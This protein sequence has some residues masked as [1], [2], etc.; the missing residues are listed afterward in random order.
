VSTKF[1]DGDR[2]LGWMGAQEAI[3][4]TDDGRERLRGICMSVNEAITKRAKAANLDNWDGKI[5][6]DDLFMILD[7]LGT[8]DECRYTYRLNG[9][10][11]HV[12][13]E[14]LRQY[15]HLTQP[16]WE[17]AIKSYKDS[18]IENWRE[19]VLKSVG[20]PKPL[21]RSLL[22]IVSNMYMSAA[23]ALIQTNAFSAAPTL[24]EVMREY[25]RYMEALKQ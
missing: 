21:P 18:G 12:S 9:R 5:E 25:E 7:T 3:G 24:D 11:L 13:K 10:P 19:L 16:E 17:E 22:E 15:Y 14:L 20:G 6:V 2:Y 23:N 1:E 4:L 8:L